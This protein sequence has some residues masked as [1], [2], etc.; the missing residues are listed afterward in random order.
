MIEAD[1][2]LFGT[3]ENYRHY[4]V[5]NQ[6]DRHAHELIDGPTRIVMMAYRNKR[7]GVHS[8]HR[9]HDKLFDYGIPHVFEF[10][11]AEAHRWDSGWLSRAVEY[12]FLERLPEGVGKALQPPKTKAQ[13][14]A[15][16]RGA[17]AEQAYES[18]RRAAG[19]VCE[20]E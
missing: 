15:L 10:H 4:A 19:L 3:N 5:L 7:D 14:A 11:E 16:H 13:V 9:F 18:D 6:I 20:R 2:K 12:L 17:L 1:E 8:V